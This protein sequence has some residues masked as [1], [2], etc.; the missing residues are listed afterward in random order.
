M[1]STFYACLWALIALFLGGAWGI[2]TA[3][4]IHA[5]RDEKKHKEEND[6][7]NN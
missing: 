4:L 3:A 2:T 6:Y 1:I 5:A 7:D